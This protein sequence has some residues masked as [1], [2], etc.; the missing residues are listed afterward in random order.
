[1]SQE[2]IQI[3]QESC[4]SCNP[5]AKVGQFCLKPLRMIKNAKNCAECYSL[6]VFGAATS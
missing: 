4:L 6:I 2:H 3:L 5:K 1:M